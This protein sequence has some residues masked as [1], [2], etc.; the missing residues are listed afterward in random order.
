MKKA[1]PEQS[2]KKSQKISDEMEADLERAEHSVGAD[3]ESDVSVKSSKPIAQ[4]KKGDKMK[5]DTLALE[6]DAHYVFIDHGTTKEMVIELFDPKTDKDYQVRYFHDRPN[7]TLE[8]YRL[9]EIIY[10]KLLVKKVEW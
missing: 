3:L 6:V 4:I 8:V 2:S 10:T 1:K 5:I 7:A 9:D